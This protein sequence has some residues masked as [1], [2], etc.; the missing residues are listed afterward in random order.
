MSSPRILILHA[1]IGGGHASAANALQ[2]A[3]AQRGITNV[4]VKDVFEFGGDLLRRAV[5]GTYTVTSERAPLL[6]KMF[7]ESG[8]VSDPQWAEFKNLLRGQAQ[9]PLFV[10]T[11]DR[12]VKKLAPDIIIG[13]HF[14]P[15]EI[16]LPLKRKSEI[17]APLYEVITDYMVSSDWIQQ[18][19]DAYFVASDFT[20][21]AMIARQVDP[22]LIHVT[23]IPVNPEFATPKDRLA[24]RERLGFSTG[25]VVTLLGGGIQGKR[26][27]RV[28]E[29]LLQ[30]NLRGTLVVVAGRNKEL[31][32]EMSQVTSGPTLRLLEL[33]FIDFLDDLIAA[34]DVVITKAGGLTV[35]EILARGT[36][37]IVIDPI[38][39]QE[40]W[41]A[42]FVAGSG[43]GIQ[44]RL[45]E[46]APAAA[47]SILTEPDR[48]EGMRLHARQAG[49]PNAALDIVDRVLNA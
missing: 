44:L 32:Q 45:I 24:A 38:P 30:T 12:Y 5:V 49:R 4:E 43:A 47:V 23:G 14:M 34:S 31:E 11:L 18:G 8:D 27:R 42:D 46:T 9:R 26:V 7:Y 13:T 16:L 35:S 28:A 3:F 19:V 29:S 25:L 2:K 36:P 20:R 39:G 33:G 40:E 6:W 15:L 17:T 48:L 41:N 37:M 22:A 21:D 10:L 1:S